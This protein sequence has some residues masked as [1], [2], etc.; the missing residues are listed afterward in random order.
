[1]Q[2]DLNSN[3]QQNS[4]GLWITTLIGKTE[5]GTKKVYLLHSNYCGQTYVDHND[6]WDKQFLSDLELIEKILS[7]LVCND[8]PENFLMNCF[9]YD[10]KIKFDGNILSVNDSLNK[11]RSGK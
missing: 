5:Y 9:R 6:D 4:I 10:D 11:F 8:T 3:R 1:M 2:T 7:N